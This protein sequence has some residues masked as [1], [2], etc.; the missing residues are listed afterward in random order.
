MIADGGG[1]E[2]SGDGAAKRMTDERS[3]ADAAGAVETPLQ[4]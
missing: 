3:N 4:L 2:A 1:G